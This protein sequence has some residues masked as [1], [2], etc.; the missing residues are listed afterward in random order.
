MDS[1]DRLFE[2]LGLEKTRRP[3]VQRSYVEVNLG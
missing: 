2:L 3:S 1:M